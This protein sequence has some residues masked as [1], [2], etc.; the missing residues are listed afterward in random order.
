MTKY[1]YNFNDEEFDTF[2]TD[3]RKSLFGGKGANLCEMTRMGFP[4]P[5]GFTITTA[6]CGIYLKEK[7]IDDNLKADIPWLIIVNLWI[8]I[9]QF[10]A[11]VS[12]HQS[13]GATLSRN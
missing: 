11:I 10:Q 6:A 3:K 9:W 1:V 5:P 8:N 2:D 7:K 12:H 4:V 13:S